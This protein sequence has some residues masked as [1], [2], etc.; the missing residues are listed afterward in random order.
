LKDI[1]S[2]EGRALLERL[3]VSEVLLGFDYDGTLAPIAARPDQARM[4]PSTRLLLA[5]LTSRYPCAV[6]SGRARGDVLRLLE[7]LALMRVV[8]NHGTESGDPPRQVPRRLIERWRDAMSS[9][10]EG[11][12]GV[13]IEDKTWSLAVH[14]RLARPK[15]AARA[16]VLATAA[17]LPDARIICGKDVVNLVHPAAANKGTAI[18][19]LRRQ[20]GCETVIY[21]GDDVTDEDVFALGERARVVAVR[22]GRTS[23]S[24]APFY[25]RSQSQVDELLAT[26]GALRPPARKVAAR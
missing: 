19:E 4:R 13:L 25:V 22:V 8:G 2:P 16:R 20:L 26:L 24:H 7:G 5:D 23:R 9:A 3:A 6:V 17:V 18:V 21:V 10:C 1:L 11:V 15:S 14:W 12:P